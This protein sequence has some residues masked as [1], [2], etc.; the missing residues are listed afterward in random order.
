MEAEQHDI[1]E[2][3]HRQRKRYSPIF[4]SQY[5][6]NGCYDQLGGVDS[7]LAEAILDCIKHDAYRINIVPTDPINY[8]SMREVDGLYPALSE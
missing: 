3:L 2:L 1:L 5:D 7:P 4:C 8:R 6:P